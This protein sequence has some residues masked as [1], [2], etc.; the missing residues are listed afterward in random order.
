M[1]QIYSLLQHLYIYALV[2]LKAQSELQVPTANQNQ[3][4]VKGH[5]TL[6]VL[7][8]YHFKPVVQF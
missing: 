6:D 3:D 2:L 5:A 7:L 4:T 1:G 8:S